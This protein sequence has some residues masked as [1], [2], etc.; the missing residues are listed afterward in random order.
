VSFVSVFQRRFSCYVPAFGPVKDAY[1]V[2]IRRAEE[3]T[4]VV[5]KQVMNLPL[6]KK[7][8]KKKAVLNCI[9]RV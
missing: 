4:L 5:V 8:E 9:A 3:N 6:I 2:F 7:R 1:A